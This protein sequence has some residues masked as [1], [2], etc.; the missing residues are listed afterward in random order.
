M[1]VVDKESAHPIS[2]DVFPVEKGSAIPTQFESDEDLGT[3]FGVDEKALIRK[4]DRTLLPAVTLLYLL[5]FLDRS[6]GKSLQSS[7]ARRRY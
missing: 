1:A 5:S 4:L 7:I 6:N 3:N 2:G